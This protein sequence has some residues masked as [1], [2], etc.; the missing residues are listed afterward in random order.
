MGRSDLINQV[1]K[2]IEKV[3]L[4]RLEIYLTTKC[5]ECWLKNIE[6][7]SH[8][9]FCQLNNSVKPFWT[10]SHTV[11]TNFTDSEKMFTNRL[12]CIA[13]GNSYAWDLIN[14]ESSNNERFS[15]PFFGDDMLYPRHHLCCCERTEPEPSTSRLEWPRQ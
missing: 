15:A 14:E 9:S 11:N 13:G 8:I 7:F 10:Y 3:I 5:H 4:F 1:I 6:W 2:S 12:G